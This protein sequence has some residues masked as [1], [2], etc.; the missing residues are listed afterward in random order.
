MTA[1]T[2][3]FEAM[4]YERAGGAYWETTIA[5]GD[6]PTVDLNTQIWKPL[7]GPADPIM[8]SSEVLEIAEP[9]VAGNVTVTDYAG[10]G[11]EVTSLA[12]SADLLAQIQSDDLEPDLIATEQYER[13]NI[14]DLNTSPNGGPAL[15]D[16][17]DPYPAS[18][19]DV[20]DNDFITVI[21]GTIEVVEPG[22]YTIQVRSDDGFGMRVVGQQFRGAYGGGQLDYDGSVIFN[23]TTGDSNTRGV[24]DL[25]AGKHDL[26]IVGFERGGGAYIEITSAQGDL[27]FANAVQWLSLGDTTELPA[28]T[29]S[30]GVFTNGPMFVGNLNDAGAVADVGTLEILYED[31]MVAVE[32]GLLD[33]EASDLTQLILDDHDTRGGM[34]LPTES[35]LPRSRRPWRGS[36]TIRERLSTIS[37]RLCWDR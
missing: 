34:P 2:H 18:S 25:A 4:F 1:G 19:P 6:V 5:A 8:P 29:D 22:T 10:L 13:T 31:L 17:P 9:G 11:V 36:P 15:S 27:P 28:Y 37:P 33:A 23:G 32:D 3:E 12:Q 20:D 30:P 14:A 21:K 16:P 7:V 26:E 35:G 24:I